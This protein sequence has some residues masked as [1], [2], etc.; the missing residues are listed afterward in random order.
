MLPIAPLS[1]NEREIIARVVDAAPPLT[2]TS[3]AE[4]AALF[5]GATS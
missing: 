1:P 3:Q 2:P 4:L 5:A